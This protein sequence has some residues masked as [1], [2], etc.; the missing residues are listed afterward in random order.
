MAEPLAIHAVGALTAVGLTALSTA[1]SVRAKVSCYRELEMYLTDPELVPV[2]GAPIFDDAVNGMEDV[3]ARF[4]AMV[5]SVA[6]EC[7]AGLPPATPSV[8]LIIIAPE[9]HRP[10]WAEIE[11]STWLQAVQAR[12]PGHPSHAPM[13]LATGSAG[14]SNAL[15]TA[16][17]LLTTGESAC[18]VIG[19][20]SYLT[21]EEVERLSATFRL[22]RPDFGRGLIPG[23]ASAGILI[24]L[25]A[26]NEEM[27]IPLIRG[28]GAANEPGGGVPGH[29]R[30]LTGTGLLAALRA[31][32]VDGVIDE[33]Q[34]DL[35]VSDLA[36][37]VLATTDSILASQRFF[38]TRREELPIILPAVSCG[39]TGAAAGVLGVVVAAVA[40]TKGY[41]R[42][43][44]V[45][46]EA[47]SETSL[48]SVCVV[49][50]A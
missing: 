41:A 18:L 13:L 40:L 23:E 7:L 5:L 36:G 11:P 3:G 2:V 44:A 34:F 49:T 26:R 10:C 39:A 47:A 37:E 46:C 45:A 24:R 35:R 30:A 14:I 17:E 4:E 27:A 9:E 8:P 50:L 43:R 32:A 16:R 31:A 15:R 25:V 42:A 19:V 12:L 38:R 1:A 22:K 6:E 21:P 48:R 29:R 20:D 33:S 28:V